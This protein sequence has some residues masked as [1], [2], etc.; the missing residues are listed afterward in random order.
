MLKIR[1]WSIKNAHLIASKLNT[2]TSHTRHLY[3]ESWSLLEAAFK[4]HFVFNCIKSIALLP[5]SFQFLISV[6][7]TPLHFSSNLK[8][9]ILICISVI[10]SSRVLFCIHSLNL[11]ALF[12]TIHLHKKVNK[13]RL[14]LF[15]ALC[16]VGSQ[17]QTHCSHL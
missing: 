1:I 3:R 14:S 7:F 2:L 4:R 15:F 12:W 16:G 11:E 8:P 6:R 9:P 17:D 13:V 10:R 5:H